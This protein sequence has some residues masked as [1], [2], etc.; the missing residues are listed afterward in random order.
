MA[1]SLYAWEMSAQQWRADPYYV[2]SGAPVERVTVVASTRE[3]AFAE[4]WRVL[5][6]ARRHRVWKGWVLG[7]K[8]VRITEPTSQ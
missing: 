8:D 4:L 7:A 6:P 1:E 2:A 3:E 5:G